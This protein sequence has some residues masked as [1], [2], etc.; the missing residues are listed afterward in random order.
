MWLGRDFLLG[1]QGWGRD[2]SGAAGMSSL[3]ARVEWKLLNLHLRHSE[4]YKLTYLKSIFLHQLS[5]SGN[6]A[7]C[8][9]KWACF[10]RVSLKDV[11]RRAF[12]NIS[13][14]CLPALS[15]SQTLHGRLCHCC[16]CLAWSCRSLIWDL[17]FPVPTPACYSHFHLESNGAKCSAFETVMPHNHS[18]LTSHDLSS[19]PPKSLR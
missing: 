15:Q 11:K 9:G 8:S 13:L 10:V 7:P 12:E 3:G 2:S 18:C 4:T 6:L 5:V 17:P 19:N 1:A 14:H 16:F